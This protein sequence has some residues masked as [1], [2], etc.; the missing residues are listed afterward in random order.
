MKAMILS[1]C[2][3]LLALSAC[4]EKPKQPRF[5]SLTRELMLIDAEGKRYG[6]VQLDPLGGGKMYDVEGR[7]VGVITAPAK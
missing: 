2:A 5:E 6:T 1:S 3:L 4:A 7:M